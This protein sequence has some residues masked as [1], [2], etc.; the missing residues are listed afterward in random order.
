M[1]LRRDKESDYMKIREKRVEDYE[2]QLQQIR[3]QDAEEY[4]QVKIKLENDVQVCRFMKAFFCIQIMPKYIYI[5]NWI[6][7]A[8]HSLMFNFSLT[9]RKQKLLDLAVTSN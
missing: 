5:C 6:K 8:V 1:Q 3:V 7:F 9:S 4:N 2:D